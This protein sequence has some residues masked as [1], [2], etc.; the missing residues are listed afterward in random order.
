MQVNGVE[1]GVQREIGKQRLERARQCHPSRG[2]L[3]VAVARQL[4][5]TELFLGARDF[6]VYPDT[7]SA[8]NYETPDTERLSISRGSS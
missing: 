3:V 1:N 7:I 4:D 2:I 6:T 5:V 8:T